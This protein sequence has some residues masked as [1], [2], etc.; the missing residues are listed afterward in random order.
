M[1]LFKN[2]AAVLLTMHQK[3]DVIFPVLQETG[4]VL[5]VNKTYDTDLLGT[6]TNEIARKGSQL[7]AARAKALKAIEITGHPIGIASEGSFGAHP[8][9]FFAPADY[10]LVMLVDAENEI[11]IVGWELS[12]DTN[13]S[14]TE[15]A[16]YEDALTFAE[17]IGFPQHGLVAKYLTSNGEKKIAA[18]GLISSK[19]LKQAIAEAIQFSTDGKV[20]LETDMRAMYNPT[21][22]KV[23]LLY[24]SDAADE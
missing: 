9:I 2:R 14:G 22:M 17:T 12:T 11:E 24:T 23:C 15:V 10:E 21:R 19:A 20:Y 7:D 3:E 13:F 4:M 6:F 16:S 18:K 5:K 1:E 8:Y